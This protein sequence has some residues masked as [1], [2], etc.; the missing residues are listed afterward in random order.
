MESRKK[1]YLSPPHLGDA[2]RQMIEEALST[3]W[4][5]PVGP[6]VEQFE[7][8]LSGYVGS[9]GAAALNSGTAALHLALKLAGAG[10][11]DRVFCST[12]TFVASANP[13]RYAGAEPVFIDSEPNTWN[14]SPLALERAFVDAKKARTVP[15]AVIVVHL[16][17]QCADMDPILRICGHYGVPVIEDAAESL[18]ADYKGR[19]SGTMGAMGV[20]SFNGNKIITTSGGGMLVSGNS[21]LVEK[22]RFL[23]AQARDPALHYQHSEIGF[24]YR[25]SNVLAGI[26]RGQLQVLEARI[27][28]R[29]AVFDRYCR[30]LA[31]IEGIEFAPE[32][33]HGRSTR[34]LTALTVD[35]GKT[36]VTAAQIIGALADQ[37]IEARPV[38]KPMHLQPLYDRCEYVAHSPEESVSDHLFTNGLCLP[39][40]SNLSEDEQTIVTDC[41]RNLLSNAR[42]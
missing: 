34:W 41:I 10:T 14:M 21:E 19:A 30:A 12:L 11:G 9:A 39:S 36:G 27:R 22:A 32:A 26:G 15:K 20:Y 38:W 1:I 25:L 17:G 35:A 33:P 28:A 16:Y 13:I 6:H 3:N 29:R 42:K 18:G 5:A 7:H 23:A 31:G 2:E 4:I 24:N 40:G 8:E 37:N